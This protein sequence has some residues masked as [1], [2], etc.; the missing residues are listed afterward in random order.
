M[1]K[2]GTPTKIIYEPVKLGLHTGKVYA[3]VHRDIYGLIGD[4]MAYGYRQLRENDIDPLV[5]MTKFR[6]ALN[7]K[8]GMPVDVTINRP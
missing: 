7:H 1:V 8:N 5:D 6:Q 4:F 2:I 3:E